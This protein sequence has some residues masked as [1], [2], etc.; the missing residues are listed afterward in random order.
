MS[1]YSDEHIKLLKS[2]LAFQVKF[3]LV[4]GHAAIYY[5]VNRN[6][7]DLDIL[8]EPTQ[9]N[10]QRLLNALKSIGL[11]VPDIPLKEFET[12]LVLSFGLEPDAV[13]ILNFTPGIEFNS[14]FDKAHR[15]NFSELKIPIIDIRDLISNKEQLKRKGEKS[16]LD[17]YDAEVLKKILKRKEMD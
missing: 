16:L 12:E 8:I 10:G 3:I 2:L 5:G 9:Q 7:G 13:D 6:T 4:G 11:E 1:F 17:K 15:V 14:A